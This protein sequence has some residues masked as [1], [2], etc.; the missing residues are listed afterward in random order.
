MPSGDLAARWSN[1][2]IEIVGQFGNGPV[3]GP[4]SSIL[5][6]HCQALAQKIE[7]EMSDR[8]A[9]S[10]YLYHRQLN[11]PVLDMPL[12]LVKTD[13]DTIVLVESSG[14]ETVARRGPVGF[15]RRSPAAFVAKGSNSPCT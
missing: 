13:V 2:E 12:G 7:I 15:S 8:R 6:Q 10:W 3:F 11:L 1:P 5:H 9:C 4:E 14:S